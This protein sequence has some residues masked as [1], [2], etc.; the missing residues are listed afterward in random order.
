VYL[1]VTAVVVV[2]GNKGSD[3]TTNIKKN[4]GGKT[5]ALTKRNISEES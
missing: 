4:V 5:K 1:T 3:G 2:A